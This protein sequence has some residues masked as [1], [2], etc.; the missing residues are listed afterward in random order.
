MELVKYASTKY[1]TIIPEIDMPGHTNAALASYP[2]LNC[3][4]VATELYT[5]TDVGF[6]SLCINKSITYEFVE[7]VIRELSEITP[8]SYI[9]IGGDENLVTR[10]EDYITFVETIQQ[11]VY[12]HGKVLVGWEEVAQTNLINGS[13]VQ[14]WKEADYIEAA[15]TEQLSLIMSP[16]EFTYL[17]M[18]YNTDTAL[19]LTWAGYINVEKAYNWEPNNSINDASKAKIVGVEAPLWTETITNI[20][21]L[22]YMAFPRLLGFAETA[23]SPLE[24]KNW[25]EYRHRLA[26]QQTYFDL[27]DT[28]FYR[29]DLI[30]WGN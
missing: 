12:A 28:N 8:G 16:A 27:T 15:A 11:T 26:A 18:K 2:E 10:K 23:W 30:P 20:E 29:S 9:H 3:N 14:L 19:G 22:E 13:Y 21:E 24:N 1:I 6:S 5:G 4:N 25:N 7:D 17:D